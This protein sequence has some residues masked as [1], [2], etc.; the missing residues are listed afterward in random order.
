MPPGRPK[1][2]KARA[3]QVLGKACDER[4]EGNQFEERADNKMWLVRHLEV[5]RVLL[6]EDLR[7]IKTLC[8]PCFPP[9][10]DIVNQ[11][12]QL[13]HRRL[14]SHVSRPFFSQLISCTHHEI[15]GQDCTL[16]YLIIPSCAVV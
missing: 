15:T 4:I 5:T 1:R 10:W 16:H 8:L 7:V 14:A 12:V 9:N 3:L 6:L 2:W 11:F 13:Y